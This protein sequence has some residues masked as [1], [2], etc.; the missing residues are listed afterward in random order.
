MPTVTH[1]R[2]KIYDELAC[3]AGRRA[4]LAKPVTPERVAEDGDSRVERDILWS[5]LEQRLH[6]V[7]T[8]TL[9]QIVEWLAGL[10]CEVSRQSVWRARQW[11]TMQERRVRLAAEKAQ[12]VLRTAATLGVDDLMGANQTLA[13]QLIF[14]CLNN[15]GAEALEGMD[16]PQVIRMIEAFGRLQSGSASA[17]LQRVKAEQM[18][19]AA[20][21]AKAE[22]D[23]AADAGGQVSRQRVAEIL[24]DIMSGK[25]T[26]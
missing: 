8:W 7:Q 18:R 23:K 19:R 14:D 25:E 17:E 4:G 16:P 11:V 2:Y 3:L 22:V 24:D 12:A 1:R 6:D 15:L 10:G 13:M 9:D 21:A 5:E 20:D 26:A